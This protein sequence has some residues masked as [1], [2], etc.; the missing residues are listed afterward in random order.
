MLPRRFA[1]LPSGNSCYFPLKEK[2]DRQFRSI[3]G[4]N[5]IL[6]ERRK[7]NNVISLT[8]CPDEH[9]DA[10]TLDTLEPVPTASGSS[11]VRITPP[12]EGV[13]NRMDH[14]LG[15]GYEFNA[16]GH[17]C[18]RDVANRLYKIDEFGKRIIS[19]TTTCPPH[20]D[21]ET[22]WHVFTPKDRIKWCTDMKEKE[23]A[24]LKAKEAS[25]SSEPA[26]VA[27]T[28]DREVSLNVLREGENKGGETTLQ[29]G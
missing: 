21:S 14:H 3:D 5:E 1:R 15:I 28:D 26:V 6:T 25:A 10:D 2:Y 24:E 29:G 4:I 19:R 23:I 16:E 11:S 9:V 20:L 12:Q 22:W 18:R 17:L 13:L 7:D 8:A 27:S